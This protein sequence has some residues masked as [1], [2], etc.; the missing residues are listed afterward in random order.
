MTNKLLTIAS[1]LLLAVVPVQATQFQYNHDL[2]CEY[3]VIADIKS[4]TCN[5]VDTC[6]LGEE[7]KVYGSIT[8]EEDL[9]SSSLCMTVKSCFLGIKFMC[10]THYEKVDVCE[11]LGSSSNNGN[12]ACPNAGSFYF[13][14]T[15]E[16]PTTGDW[17]AV[18]SGT[19][20]VRCRHRVR[21]LAPRG[22]LHSIEE[23]SHPK[24]P[25]NFPLPLYSFSP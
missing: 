12:T 22:A 17:M 11:T 25:P 6:Y 9:P 5:G 8:L 18:G 4:M 7:M 2:F 3:P 23:Y 13:D 14:Y 1:C 24:P 16:L 20:K 15:L 21:E 19:H 10:K